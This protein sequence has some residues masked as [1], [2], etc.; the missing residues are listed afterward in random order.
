VA[1]LH[2]GI[3]VG[4]TFTAAAVARPG[5]SPE[6][7]SLGTSGAA[8]PSVVYLREDGSVATG[9]A[10]LQRAVSEPG[11]VA[12]EFKR[13]VG[14]P[15]PIFLAGTPMAAHLVLGRLLRWVVDHIEE[16][17][18]ETLTHTVITHPA[19][20][21]EYR[22]DFL[23]QAVEWADIDSWAPLTEPEAAAIHYATRERVDP[24]DTVAVYD[25]GG[26]T[27]DAAILRRTAVGFEIVGEPHGIESLG[28]I[29]LDQAIFNHVTSQLSGEMSTLDVDDPAAKSAL[30][31]LRSEC[32]T[33]KIAL[34]SETDTTIP[35][36]LPGAHASI[37]LTR[38]EFEDLVRHTLRDTVTALERTLASAGVEPH[39]L[40]KVL[41]VG[42][43]SRIP[44]VAQM[45]TETLGRPVAVDAD[46][47]HAVALGAAIHARA[48]PPERA[49]R[50]TPPAVKA[51]PM[52]VEEPDATPEPQAPAIATVIGSFGA[53]AMMIAGQL[54][55][56]TN[57][58]VSATGESLGVF[59]VL[60][61]DARFGGISGPSVGVLAFVL[62]LVSLTTLIWMPG[63]VP[64][65]IGIFALGF[66]VYFLIIVPPY[67]NTSGSEALDPGPFVLMLGGIVVTVAAIRIRRSRP[68]D[69]DPTLG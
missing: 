54:Q 24:G 9:A 60:Q 2:A 5:G 27:F 10:A 37:R 61:G 25:L 15:A 40:T 52:P 1:D 63:W 23:R 41:L 47:K 50:Q 49:Q 53:I 29:D 28:G 3:D 21:G 19:N 6:M 57:R 14:D 30:Q 65:T 56:L 55:W 7:I 4:T 20:W 33:A 64:A 17:S 36:I 43:S 32:E 22:R 35:V 46:P 59:N 8:I 69:P 18:G 62:G 68:V 42:G 11:R 13:R 48:N 45:V 31:R 39:D 34:S 58:F 38:D 12:R 67:S 66:G 44:L 26:G 16:R 51:Q